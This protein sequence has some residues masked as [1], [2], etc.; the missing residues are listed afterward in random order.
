[1]ASTVSQVETRTNTSRSFSLACAAARAAEDNAGRDVVVLDMREQAPIFDYF[2]VVTGTSQRQL[3]AMA[4][5]IDDTM[6]KDFNCGRFGQEGYQDSA[7]V[8]LDFGTVVVH[9]FDEKS[10]EYYRLEDLWSAAQP[11]AWK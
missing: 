9:L 7:W 5:A 11:V 8:L 1:V 2:V 4:D 3:R 10:R 6:Q